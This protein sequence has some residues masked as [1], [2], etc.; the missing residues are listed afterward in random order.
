[1]RCTTAAC[2]PRERKPI[3]VLALAGALV[4][5][6][7]SAFAGSF[8]GNN[9]GDAGNNNSPPTGAIL[10]LAGGETGTPAQTV[11]HGAPIQETVSFVAALTTTDITFAFREDPAF[12]SFSDV[13]LVDTTT[14][15]G[16]LI[17]N[18]N[19]SGGTYTSNGNAAAPVD[20]TYANG[21]GAEAGGVVASCSAFG[22]SDCWYDGA[23]QAY[24]AIAQDVST[25]AGDTY[26]LSFYYTD[27]SSL[28]TMSDLSTNGDTTG[29]GGTGI[30]ILAY[31][32]AGL[33]SPVPEPVSLAVFGTGLFGLGVIRRRTSAPGT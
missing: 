25:I 5:A 1:M 19:F 15:S 32:Q 33:P 9:Y 3:K 7:S 22:S 6:A 10:D 12:I 2:S 29:T 17:L 18:G 31:A 23:V 11:N 26:T 24:D 14:P 28:T 27:G 21:Y 16:N 30:D 4:L 13:S 8:D 20:W